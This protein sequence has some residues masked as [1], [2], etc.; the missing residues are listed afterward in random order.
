[1]FELVIIV[2]STSRLASRRLAVSFLCETPAGRR[3]NTTTSSQQN[4]ELLPAAIHIRPSRKGRPTR[5]DL[6]S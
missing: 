1:L 6:V 5:I 2:T 3:N 4:N